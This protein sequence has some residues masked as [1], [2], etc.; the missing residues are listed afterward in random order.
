MLVS[1]IAFY[2]DSQK[3]GII[4]FVVMTFSLMMFI[5]NLIEYKFVAYFPYKPDD[6]NKEDNQN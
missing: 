6:G 2:M 5:M 3:V 4:A 1:I